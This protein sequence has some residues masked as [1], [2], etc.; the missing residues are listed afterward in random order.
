MPDHRQGELLN[1][2]Q[3]KANV[4]GLMSAHTDTH[5]LNEGNILLVDDYIGSGNSLSEACRVL[6]KNVGFQGEIVPLTVAKIR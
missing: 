1:Q 3:R 6:R 5:Q 2:D 4:K